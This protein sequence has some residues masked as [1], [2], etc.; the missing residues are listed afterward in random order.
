MM[1][2]VRLLKE[3]PESS[4]APSATYEPE[5]RFSPATES[6]SILILDF[7]ASRKIRNKLLLFISLP[8]YGILL[9]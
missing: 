8:V 7:P 5:I 9:Q 1:G 2:L 6:A 3:S 4:L